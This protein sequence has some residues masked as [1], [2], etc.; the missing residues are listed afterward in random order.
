MLNN[1]M[2]LS[3]LFN[4][5]K[6]NKAIHLTL[7][8]FLLISAILMTSGALVIERLNGAIDQVMSIA[9]P[10]HVLQMH[11]GDYNTEQLQQFADQTG[12]VQTNQIQEMANIEGVNL[13]FSRADGSTVSLGDSLLDNYFV[14]QNSRFDYLLDTDNRIVNMQVGHVGVPISYARAKAI[15]V[16]DQLHVTVNGHTADYTVSHL[17]RDAQMGSSLS[18]SIRFLLHQDDFSTLYQYAPNKEV[19]IEFR[20]TDEASIDRFV[21]LYNDPDATLPNNGVQI[22]YPLIKLVNGIA[23]GLM[24]GVI[25][26]VGIVLLIIAII[27]MRFTILATLERD[28]REIG[29]LKAI[30]IKHADI[31]N[32]YKLKYRLL[33]LIACLIAVPGTFIINHLF[34]S[35]IAL[36]FGQSAYSAWTVL[37]PLIAL[38][39]FVLIVEWSLRRI[40]KRIA[41]MSV[42]EALIDGRLSTGRRAKQSYQTASLKRLFNQLDLSLSWHDLKYNR[43]SWLAVTLIF[44]LS[45]FT[46]LL[47]YNLYSTMSSSDFVR[48]VGAAKSDVRMTLQYREDLEK[49][50]EQITA[51][52]AIDDDISTYHHFKRVRGTLIG[53]EKSKAFVVE[54]GDYGGFDIAMSSGRLPTKDGEIALSTLN[55]QALDCQLGDVLTIA[56]NDI[57]YS[58]TVVGSYQDITNGGI[59]AKISQAVTGDTIDNAFFIDLK[60]GVDI[61]NFVER[62]ENQ[63]HDSKVM[64][65][66]T[67]IDQTLGTITAS[68]NV[69]VKTVYLLVVV[70]IGMLAVLFTGL[71]IAKKEGEDGVLLALGFKKNQL[72]VMYLMRMLLSVIVGTAVG[73]LL[74]ITLGQ[75]LMGVVVSLMGFGITQLSFLVNP[76]WLLL[77]GCIVPV[78][79]AMALTWQM[80]RRI[81]SSIVNQAI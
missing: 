3:L 15:A 41:K 32:L 21:T 58:F 24:S 57:D 19:L 43:K 46:M 25:I 7:F 35:N 61:N 60:Q 72:R 36:N 55:Q 56:F 5:L 8:L 31:A 47:P 20:L 6:R 52:L 38:I 71:Q 22:T 1:T 4:D 66:D 78:V 39:G 50:V 77:V 40:L 73:I 13:S 34:T 9:K 30:G 76:L 17:I 63:H 16:G 11:I 37:A 75:L 59:T 80:T 42:L 18:S 65:V 23:D 74:S 14:K 49:T 67:L 79:T 44:V 28:V 69:A 54:I 2:T 48:Y 81:N 51:Q 26:L 29:T 33:T 53:A 45:S 70:I 12:L 62:L 27:T 68:L 64:A 10:P